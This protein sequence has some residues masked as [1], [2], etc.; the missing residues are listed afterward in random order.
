M[1]NPVS[2]QTQ[3]AQLQQAPK[4]SRAAGAAANTAA[5]QKADLAINEKSD[6]PSEEM[7]ESATQKSTEALRALASQEA[8]K[9]QSLPAKNIMNPQSVSKAY[10]PV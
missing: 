9:S 1:I 4:A 8:A 6:P 7:K 3:L 2:S 10:Q 5:S